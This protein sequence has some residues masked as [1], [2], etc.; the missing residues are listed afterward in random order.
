[1]KFEH[2]I[3]RTTRADQPPATTVPT[4][5][6]CF[7]T[8]W[9]VI[10]RSNGALWEPYSVTGAAE[11]ENGTFTPFL[12][13]E[14]DSMSPAPGVNYLEQ[15]GF[16]QRITTPD[17]RRVWHWTLRIMLADPPVTDP[18]AD[19]VYVAGFPFS[20]TT[21]SPYDDLPMMLG[22]LGSIT[23][24][25]PLEGTMYYTGIAALQTATNLVR[26]NQFN[27][28]ANVSMSGMFVEDANHPP[29]MRRELAPTDRRRDA[30]R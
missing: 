21:L 6:L 5:T 8:D 1:M 25:E 27:H 26:L 20:L 13:L 4:G 24:A 29:A 3:L 15:S 9:S 11:I 7:V 12:N 28:Y 2:L 17:G 16:Y 10:E 22:Y 23:V 30:S 19:I 14:W 18:T